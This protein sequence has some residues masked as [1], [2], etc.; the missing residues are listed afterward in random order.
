MNMSTVVRG[1]IGAV[2]CAVVGTACFGGDAP[3]PG[4]APQ[5]IMKPT[6]TVATGSASG[7]DPPPAAVAPSPPPQP[8]VPTPAPPPQPFSLRIAHTEGDG[9]AVR[10]ACRDS[11]RTSQIGQGIREGEGARRV[12]GDT[13][14]CA[15]WALVETEDGHTS[16]VRL[17]YV[18]DPALTDWDGAPDA[19]WG[20]FIATLAA[21]G[22]DRDEALAAPLMANALLP[23]EPEVVTCVDH[24]TLVGLT[25]VWTWRGF[26]ERGIT[27]EERSCARSVIAEMVRIDPVA[28]TAILGTTNDLVVS[29]LW[30]CV[31]R[32]LLR[33]AALDS[34][35][36]AAGSDEVLA[37]VLATPVEHDPADVTAGAEWVV[38]TMF[39]CAADASWRAVLAVLTDTE[40]SEASVRCLR[41]RIGLDEAIGG[42][43][44][45]SG[46][47]HEQLIAA[48]SECAKETGGR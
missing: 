34:L 23:W 24:R 33:T 8:P 41:E 36:D 13:D 40:P 15:G 35:G 21:S 18:A 3:P 48:A 44:S 11:A 5:P 27:A 19:T 17:R 2:L 39:G 25:S 42:A 16:W 28:A 6:A 29:P 38:R 45:R 14:A 7:E 1:V 31:G 10:D 22:Q 43:S 30:S 12:V 37:C 47:L 4:E 20:D 32:P 46:P 9:V 26:D